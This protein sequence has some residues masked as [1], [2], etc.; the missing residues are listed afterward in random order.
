MSCFVAQVHRERT[1][2]RKKP[3][4]LSSFKCTA[5]IKIK[6]K[7]ILKCRGVGLNYFNCDLSLLEKT[8]VRKSWNQPSHRQAS[9]AGC[10]GAR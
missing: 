8:L 10:S 5:A 1:N 4:K 2:E 7:F 9:T 6:H 3:K